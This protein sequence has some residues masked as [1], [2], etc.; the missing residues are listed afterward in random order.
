MA[1]PETENVSADGLSADFPVLRESKSEA[2]ILVFGVT[3]SGKSTLIN[4]LCGAVPQQKLSDPD[5]VQ[6][7]AK[8]GHRLKHETQQAMSYEARSTDVRTSDDE[9]T[10]RKFTVRV[11]DTPGFSDG[12]TNDRSYVMQANVRCKDGIDLLLYCINMA[13]KKCIID[14]MVPGM[15]TVTE[16]LG[17][18]IWKHAIIVLT[19]ANNV[20]P[21]RLSESEVAKCQDFLD[22]VEH[23][24]KK[25]QVAL[26]RAGVSQTMARNVAIEP[27]GHFRTPHLPDRPHWLG[28]LWL[29]VMNCIKDSAK[30][31]ILVNTQEYVVNSEFLSRS[32]EE[33]GPDLA[34]ST[35]TLT[36]SSD[37]G[38]VFV[39]SISVVG[40]GEGTSSP[41][42][43]RGAPHIVIDEKEHRSALDTLLGPI[44]RWILAL[45]RKKPI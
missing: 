16:I 36:H 37:E 44:K 28:Y 3:G 35:H 30:I 10:S 11:W 24:R 45:I 18:E 41:V 40:G 43:S 27:A 25:I 4:S 21:K 23:W 34:S 12:T 39:S 6:L 5:S 42:T 14:E 26:T 8:V 7:P 32:T 13:K 17:M 22:T 38:Y 33:E 9:C 29:M 15:R 19:F 20:K 2:N 1:T 31:S